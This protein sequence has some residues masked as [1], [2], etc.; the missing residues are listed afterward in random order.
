M[1]KMSFGCLF[2]ISFFTA[3]GEQAPPPSAPVKVPLTTSKKEFFNG[4][5]RWTFDIIRHVDQDEGVVNLV[6]PAVMGGPDSAET[7]LR[8]DVDGP[9]LDDDVSVDLEFVV[10]PTKKILPASFA[11][12]KFNFITNLE[13]MRAITSAETYSAWIIIVEA[14]PFKTLA[15]GRVGFPRLII[16]RK[17]ISGTVIAHELGHN[18]GMPSHREKAIIVNDIT[19]YAL[20]GNS[21]CLFGKH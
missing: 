10:F 14:L 3:C 1:S 12:E 17:N 15:A 6:A 7:L 2:I 9:D 13:D 8:E 20:M 4:K 19:Y 5:T 18:C 11:D 21:S 16:A